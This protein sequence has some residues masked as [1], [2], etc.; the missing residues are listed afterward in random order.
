MR[1]LTI[2][3]C[4]T[5]MVLSL[6][7]AASAKGMTLGQLKT[8]VTDLGYAIESEDDSYVSILTQGNTISF[9]LQDSGE[10]VEISENLSVFPDDGKKVVPYM[11]MLSANAESP[12][13][14]SLAR[15]DGK[16][17]VFL[18]T[19]IAASAVNKQSLRKV[20]DAWLVRVDSTEPIWGQDHWAAA[21]PP[22]APV[23]PTPAPPAAAVPAPTA[24]ATPPAT[25]IFCSP[26]VEKD[27]LT[28]QS[29]TFRSGPSDAEGRKPVRPLSSFVSGEP[30]Y[31]ALEIKGFQCNAL[32]DGKYR[33]SFNVDQEIR[34]D[35][36]SDYEHLLTI[37]Q[38]VDF[39]T[40][41]KVDTMFI[42][43]KLS[44]TWKIF[45]NYS[46]RYILTDTTSGRKAS[47]VLPLSV[48]PAK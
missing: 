8:L 21:T 12:Y 5:A 30:M 6:H 9:G 3:G 22:A 16:S 17:T 47:I 4:A 45:G 24:T 44:P 26:S 37:P 18:E 19:R 1:Y 36:D 35:S 32:G 39:D 25:P 41:Q 48:S 34:L 40:S 10:S 38:N 29:A 31:I 46:F 43:L 11:E 27:P 15:A 42:D 14:F 13:Y 7:G 33:S 2:F 20:I 23:P 28:I